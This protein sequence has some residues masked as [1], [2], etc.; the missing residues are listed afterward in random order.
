MKNNI[1]NYLKVANI[2][3]KY[4]LE[5]EILKVFYLLN[6]PNLNLI[7]DLKDYKKNRIKKY[8]IFEKTQKN[9]KKA[10]KYIK[11]K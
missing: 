3:T 6:L 11:N 4:W 8:L 2:I 1:N 10:K 7:K 9:I 5:Y